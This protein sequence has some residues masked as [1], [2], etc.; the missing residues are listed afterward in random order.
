MGYEIR[1]VITKNTARA[2]RAAR[3][4]GQSTIA[5]SEDQLNSIGSRYEEVLIGSSLILIA[6][7]DD[8]IKSIAQNLATFF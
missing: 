6:T 1:A 5:L 4:I 7:P 3:V 2:R 8:V